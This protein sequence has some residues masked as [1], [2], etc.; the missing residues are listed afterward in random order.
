MPG[1][2]YEYLAAEKPIF[3]ISNVGPPKMYINNYS[4]G[5]VSNDSSPVDIANKFNELIRSI[6]NNDFIYPKVSALK[7]KFNRKY[8][9]KDMAAVFTKSNI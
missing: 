4:L 8:I 7:D 2:F 6:E 9:A 1:K 5:I 3:C